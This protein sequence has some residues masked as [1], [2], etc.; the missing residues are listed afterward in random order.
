MNACASALRLYTHHAPF[1]RGRGAFI[2]IIELLKRRGWPPPLTD[3][4]E[5]VAMEFEPS[6][7]GWTLFETGHWEAL[8]TAA[9]LSLIQ[10][11]GVVLNV[12][13]NTGYYALLAA[14]RAG[15]QGCVHAFEI[16]PSMISILRRNIARNGLEAVVTVV[17]AGCFS[18]ACEAVIEGHGDPGSARIAFAGTGIRV[19]L[20]TLDQY[21]ATAPLERVDVIL[22]DTEGADFEI[23]KGAA[24]LLAAHHPA[25]IAEVHHLEAFGGSENE[26]RAF[27]ARFGYVARPL[28]GEFSR[29]LLFVTEGH[30]P[31]AE[32]T[33]AHSSRR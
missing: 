15:D 32:S 4:G 6:L 20:I 3:I 22:I 18:S 31:S 24:G 28:Q 23:L 29:D 9:C 26:L 33:P 12:G 7:L 1:K 17:E 27:M 16:Q 11:G 25:V 5:G 30:P 10:P 8:Q 14:A 2:R 19:P 21:A 13:A